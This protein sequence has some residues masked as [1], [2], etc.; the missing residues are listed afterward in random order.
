MKFASISALYVLLAASTTCNEASASNIPS[1]SPSSEYDQVFQIKSTYSEFDSSK[2]WCLTAEWKGIG[3]KLHVRPCLSYPSLSENLQLFATDEYGQLKLAG[4]PDGYC[5]T[6]TSRLVKLE[7]CET[8]VV[9]N[10]QFTVDASGGKLS[11]TKRGQTYYLGFANDKMLSRIRLFKEG[12]FNDSFDKWSVVY[13]S[14]A[15]R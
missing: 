7:N 1:S 8:T 6:A 15:S 10:K 2:E 13:G 3:S 4:P 14:P 5:V 9:A 12:F 11:Q